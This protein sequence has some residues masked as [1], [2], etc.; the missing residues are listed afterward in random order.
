[1]GG[2]G[3]SEIKIPDYRIYKIDG[4]KELE[5]VRDE[6]AKKGLKDPWLR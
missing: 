3:H 4:I 2:G 6:L 5:W 1:M